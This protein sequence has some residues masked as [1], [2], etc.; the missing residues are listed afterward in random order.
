MW[1]D[2]LK[3]FM[4]FPKKIDFQINVRE[5]SLLYCFKNTCIISQKFND[6]MFEIIRLITREISIDRGMAGGIERKYLI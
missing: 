1:V 2:K 4:R 6:N 5:L 3:L